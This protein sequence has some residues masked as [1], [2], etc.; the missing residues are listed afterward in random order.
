MYSLGGFKSK[1]CFQGEV[2]LE[3][4]ASV[5]KLYEVVKL[6]ANEQNLMVVGQ[7]SFRGHEESLRKQTQSRTNFRSLTSALMLQ[8]LGEHM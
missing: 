1:D 4:G 7:V 8:F 5:L 2:V 3:T 6:R